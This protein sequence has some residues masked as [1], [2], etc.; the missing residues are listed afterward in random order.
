M[1]ER[2]DLEMTKLMLSLRKMGGRIY[3]QVH[4]VSAGRQKL[5]I[6]QKQE[7]ISGLRKELDEIY[8]RESERRK[9]KKISNG[10]GGEGEQFYY[11]CNILP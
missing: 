1:D 3:K 9:L 4:S 6:E 2:D 5:T 8:S 11:K 10:S 7:I